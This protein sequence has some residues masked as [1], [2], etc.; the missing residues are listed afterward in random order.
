MSKK[1]SSGFMELLEAYFVTYLPFSKGL[2]TNTIKSYKQSFLL[3]LDFIFYQKGIPADRLKFSDLN[4]E[5]LL[6]FFTWIETERN[7]KTVTRNQRLSAIAAFSEYAQNRDFNAASVF[8]TSINKISLKKGSPKTR[9]V[10][11][12]EEVSL[13]LALPNERTA[14]GLRDKVLLSIMYASGAR[15]Q[16]ICDLTVRNV[17]FH[18][19]TSTLVLTGKGNKTRRIGLPSNCT[20]MLKKYIHHRHIDNA[21]IRHVFSSQTHEQMT[22]SC[23]EGIFKKYVSIAKKQ[24]PSMFQGDS[25]PPH[26]MRHSTASHLLEAGVDI[27]T[28]KNILGHVSLQTTQI[29]AEMS[30]ETV[31]KKLCEWNDSWFGEDITGKNY[32]HE[33]KDGIPTFL[34][35]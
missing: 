4:Y 5:T 12:R 27:V 2:S 21:Y 32:S 6:D 3:L 22:V 1:S 19:K 31:N 9:A 20:V 23:V 11:T 25:Y 34:R 14:T 18:D 33:R 8:R 30:Q 24:H 15:A 29:Y 28:I 35:R 13:L 17:Q 7:C 16:E 10:F 26:S